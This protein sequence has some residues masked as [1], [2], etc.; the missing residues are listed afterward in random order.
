MTYDEWHAQ[1][2]ELLNATVLVATLMQR[3]GSFGIGMMYHA[4]DAFNEIELPFDDEREMADE[5]K[6]Y[7]PPAEAWMSIAGEKLFGLCFDKSAFN[8][9]RWALWK[10]R[11]AELAE[12]EDIDERCRG[13]ARKAVEKMRG[14]EQRVQL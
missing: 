5:W 8:A 12:Q 14:I 9:D 2:E 7:I 10:Q 3:G 1:E 11:F 6:M 13:F 4:H